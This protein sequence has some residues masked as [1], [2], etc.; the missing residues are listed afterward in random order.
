[1]SFDA[2]IGR[3][4]QILQLQQEVSDPTALASLASTGGAGLAPGS[5]TTP[6]S[7]DFAAALASAQGSATATAAGAEP[8]TAGGDQAG[9][10][11]DPTALLDSSAL[12]LSGTSGAS[13]GSLA[14]LLGT[15]GLTGSGLTAGSDPLA[16]LGIGASATGAGPAAGQATGPSDPRIAAMVQQANSLV[17]LPYVWGGGHSGWGKQS[18]YDCSG[19]VSS[20]LHAGGYLSTP[21]D[22]STLPSAA[23]IE[24]G[25][26]QYVTI[27]DRDAAGQEGHVIIEIDG[28]FYESGG[29]SGAWG[30]GAG[31]ERIGTPSASYLATFN[32]ILHPAGL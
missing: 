27:Y 26:G 31:V 30:G 12:E 1:M 25:P 16:G 11:L 7:S 8:A 10:G 15:S 3:I 22:T 20:V 28:Q 5:S 19:F 4:D 32:T 14:S 24:P 29:A 6:A 13:S 17:G 2:A 21:Q 9:A 18:G 23:G